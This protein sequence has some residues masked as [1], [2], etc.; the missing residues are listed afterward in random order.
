[1]KT[2]DPF[3]TEPLV[4][5]RNEI[6]AEL[7]KNHPQIKALQDVDDAITNI[8]DEQETAKEKVYEVE[9]T[10]TK[11]YIKQIKKDELP[12]YSLGR[13]FKNMVI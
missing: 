3:N 6:D 9:I 7:E 13:W 4:Q 8:I 12:L 5:K 10:E 11:K 2:N 1:M